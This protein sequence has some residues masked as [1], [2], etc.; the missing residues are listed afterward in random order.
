MRIFLD[1]SLEPLGN[2]IG[3]MKSLLVR[4][5]FYNKS[6]RLLRGSHSIVWLCILTFSLQNTLSAQINASRKGVSE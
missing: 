1:N 6:H 2:K 3:I 5:V 4:E